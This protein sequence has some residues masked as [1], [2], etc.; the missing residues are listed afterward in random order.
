MSLCACCYIS[1]RSLLVTRQSL[2]N[3]T[4]SLFG[5]TLARTPLGRA[6]RGTTAALLIASNAPDIDFVA[7]V[8]G[9]AKYLEWHRGPTHGPL[10]VIGLAVLTAAIVEW[11]RRLNPKWR[12]PDDASFGMLVVVSLVGVLFHVLMDLP[13][14]YGTRLLSPFSWRWFAVDWMPIVDVYL[15]VVLAAGLF[16][17]P[18]RKSPAARQNAFVALTFAAAIYGLR[19]AAHHQAIEVAPRMFGPTLPS[20]CDPPLEPAAWLDSWPR[21]APSAPQAGRRCLAQLAAIPT[22]LS[23]FNWR[24][25]A[26]MSNSFELHDVNL[27][28]SR[29]HGPD[30]A[31]SGFWRLVI[32][33]PNVW[34]PQIRQAAE[35]HLGRVFL[36]FSRFPAARMAVDAEGGVTVRFTDVRF[37]TGPM[38][39]DQPAPRMELF[40][41]TITFDAQGHVTSERLGR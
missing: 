18:K 37:A 28:D 20:R 15:I 2:D 36:G 6:G 26:H 30:T 23:P 22:F 21:P 7:I 32:R 25:V 33:Y 4:H 12:H 34:T 39:A 38:V 29:L 35:T 5:A 41:A 14:S 3:L 11:A 9:P 16:F 40:T 1:R 24:I 19:A 31:S 17:L 13:T 8:G 10:G 27:L